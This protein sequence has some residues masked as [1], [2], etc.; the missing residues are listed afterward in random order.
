MGAHG[1]APLRHCGGTQRVQGVGTLPCV[2]LTPREVIARYRRI[3]AWIAL[4]LVC[5]SSHIAK[6]DNR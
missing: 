4:A 2:A 3:G 5:N 1:H 6:Y